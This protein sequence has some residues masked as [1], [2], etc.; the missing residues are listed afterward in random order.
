MWLKFRKFVKIEK[1]P[2][3]NQK[4]LVLINLINLKLYRGLRAKTDY[5][6]KKTILRRSRFKVCGLRADKLDKGDKLKFRLELAAIC[7]HNSCSI[8]DFF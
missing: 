5:M 2:A 3:S 1:Q 8:F 4:L 6:S 7:V